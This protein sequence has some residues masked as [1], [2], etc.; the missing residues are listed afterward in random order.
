M[1]FKKYGIGETTEFQFKTKYGVNLKSK[2][3]FL[4]NKFK[5]TFNCLN[6]D[7]L[8]ER[9]LFENVKNNIKYYKEIKSFRGIRHVK[10]LP[11][12]GQ[13]THTNAT[14]KVAKQKFFL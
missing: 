6:K 13:R 11:V 12:R 4:T 2:T 8:I 1:N 3:S 9:K 10:G 7:R 14:K 5:T